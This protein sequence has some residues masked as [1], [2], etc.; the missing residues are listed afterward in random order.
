MYYNYT[1]KSKNKQP[2]RLC[3]LSVIQ[4]GSILSFVINYHFINCQELFVSNQAAAKN[5]IMPTKKLDLATAK[6]YIY[7]AKRQ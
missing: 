6:C 4:T 2:L 5:Q 3:N 1:A 7:F